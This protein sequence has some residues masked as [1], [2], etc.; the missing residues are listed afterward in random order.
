M[1]S[2]ISKRQQARNERAL[3]DLLRTVPGNDVC[4][5]CQ[6]RN[7]GLPTQPV[8]PDAAADIICR[9][10]KLERMCMHPS[11][12]RLSGSPEAIG[13]RDTY[14]AL[15]E[16]PFAARC[17]PL[18]AMCLPSSQTRHPYIKSQVAEHGH[19]VVRAGRGA[20]LP[21]I[22]RE[23]ELTNLVHEKPWKCPCQQILQS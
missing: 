4:A 8:R 23:Q 2:V 13:S 11:P 18:H 12:H 16:P 3:Q 9:L 20:C 5:D 19:M 10:G 6:A 1:A 21:K 17:L 15:T 14:K 7:P 22:L